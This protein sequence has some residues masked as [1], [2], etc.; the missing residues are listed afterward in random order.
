MTSI[1]MADSMIVED[2]KK[3]TINVIGDYSQSD[4][5]DTYFSLQVPTWIPNSLLSQLLA[6]ERHTG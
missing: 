5:G 3:N 2:D 6:Q 4:D 1:L